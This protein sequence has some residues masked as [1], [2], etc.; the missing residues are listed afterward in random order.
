MRLRPNS[1]DTRKKRSERSREAIRRV[2]HAIRRDF[3]SSGL[4]LPTHRAAANQRAATSTSRPYCMSSSTTE[5]SL[6]PTTCNKGQ[7][8]QKRFIVGV[9]QPASRAQ[10]PSMLVL[11]VGVHGA[12]DEAANV[13][14]IG[15]FSPGKRGRQAWHLGRARMLA[16]RE[17]RGAPSPGVSVYCGHRRRRSGRYR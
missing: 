13:R 11:Q 7:T 2:L 6:L 10:E 12:L 17:A 3:T 4:P 8:H 16:R 9:V 14:Y 5:I 1:L 15:G